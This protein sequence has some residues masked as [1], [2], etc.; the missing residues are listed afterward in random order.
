MDYNYD[1]DFQTAKKDI[2]LTEEAKSVIAS[3]CKWAKFLAVFGFVVM[4]LYILAIVV[5]MLA[6]LVAGSAVSELTGFMSAAMFVAIMAVAL[7]V[8]LIYFFPLFYLYNYA[9]KGAVAV[10]MGDGAAM[11][12]A[13]VNLKR[14]FK[15]IGI[16]T[17][18]A[19]AFYLLSVLIVIIVGAFAGFGEAAD[20][21]NMY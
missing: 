18:A 3:S 4:G 1:L 12:E 17:V 6:V 14:C 15:F 9:A 8:S 20:I 16:M 5:M 2:V 11:T 19:M 7:V 13:F 10:R 21:Y